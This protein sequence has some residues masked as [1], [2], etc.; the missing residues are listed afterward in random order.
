M[1]GP[2]RL[3]P[4]VTLEETAST[5]GWPDTGEF[6]L[7]EIVRTLAGMDA[8]RQVSPEGTRP[9]RHSHPAEIA[10]LSSGSPNALLDAA[11]VTH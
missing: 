5:A 4:G 6:P 9:Q 11:N 10:A 8:L 2:L 1:A 7:I 3:P